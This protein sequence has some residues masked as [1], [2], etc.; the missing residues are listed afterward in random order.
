MLQLHDLLYRGL[1][2]HHHR[3]LNLITNNLGQ[4]F[5]YNI[6][7]FFFLLLSG[8]VWRYKLSVYKVVCCTVCTLTT[9]QP[10]TSCTLQP[11]VHC[12]HASKQSEQPVFFS[13]CHIW[14]WGREIAQQK[15]QDS[16]FLHATISEFHWL[17][18]FSDFNFET[19]TVLWNNCRLV[20]LNS[21]P[22]REKFKT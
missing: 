22:G 6:S 4:F 10:T 8:G 7:I 15:P 14:A 20:W 3:I 2:H 21:V 9:I 17:S 12:S 1:V 11:H 18:N 5:S 16:F 13:Y 19:K